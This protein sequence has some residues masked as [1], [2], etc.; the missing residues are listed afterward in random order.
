[1]FGDA[2]KL[3]DVTFRRAKW[4]L[5]QPSWIVMAPD[6]HVWFHPND[7]CWRD[8]FSC[9][10]LSLRGLVV[11]ELTH[12]WQHQQGV[13]LL[14]GR[15]PWARYRYLPLTPGKPFQSYGIEQQAEIVRHAFLLR[16]GAR[17]A[18]TPALE[19]YRKLLPFAP[20]RAGPALTGNRPPGPLTDGI[21]EP[22]ALA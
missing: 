21:E 5:L 14:V 19:V 6:G 3:E 12:V 2:I 22:P 20:W 4:W 10:S 1:V 16:E 15:P 18:G 8:D 17:L 11:H 9:A 7:R 13:R